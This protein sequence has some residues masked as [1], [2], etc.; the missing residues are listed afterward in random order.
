MVTICLVIEVTQLVVEAK[1]HDM[2]SSKW[3]A[4][5]TILEVFMVESL[6]LHRE[7]GRHSGWVCPSKCLRA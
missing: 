6:A 2:Y 4:I 7:H 3:S 5:F 1:T